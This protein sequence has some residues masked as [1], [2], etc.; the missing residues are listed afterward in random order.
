MLSDEQVEGLGRIIFDKCK[1]EGEL[2]EDDLWKDVALAVIQYVRNATLDE[3]AQDVK[4]LMSF[5]D[6]LNVEDV[7]EGLDPTFYITCSQSGDEGIASRIK[8]IREKYGIVRQ[9]KEGSDG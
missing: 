7:P 1:V 2:F 5:V 8:I 3:V 9:M 6:Y 4:F